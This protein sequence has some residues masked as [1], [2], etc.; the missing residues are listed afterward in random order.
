MAAQARSKSIET[1]LAEATAQ[2]RELK[3]KQGQ[4]EARNQLLEKVAM[5]N[6]G[7]GTESAHSLLWKVCLSHSHVQHIAEHT[8]H[9]HTVQ[10]LAFY[11]WGQVIASV[12]TYYLDADTKDA[13]NKRAVQQIIV[14]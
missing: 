13:C 6:K 12:H 9:C 11:G 3:V 8:P 10:T 4:L 2:V 7:S 1:Q 14:Q 5:L